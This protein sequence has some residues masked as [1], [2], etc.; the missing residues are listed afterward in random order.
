[1]A[2]ELEPKLDR[3]NI[4]R[5]RTLL[6]ANRT[7]AAKALTTVAY[8]ARDDWRRLFPPL[9]KLRRR[10][11]ITGARVDKATPGNLVS[12][13]KNDDKF[14]GRHVKGIDTPKRAATSRL[15]VPVEPIEQQGTHKTIRSRLR[16]MDQTRRKTFTVDDL[17]VRGTSNKRLPL[18]VVGFLRKEVNIEPRFDAL[19]VT[20]H[21]V[22][23]NF[24][25]IYASLLTKWAATGKA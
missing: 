9:F 13:V 23:K 1:M 4:T 15:F 3:K 6:K 21:S 11:L 5:F 19:G 12:A 17:V 10:W 16:R 20:G 14:F 22:R 2:V 18:K 25:R 24:R 7:M 8:A